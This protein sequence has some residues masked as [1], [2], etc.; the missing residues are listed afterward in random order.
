M[1]P[2]SPTNYL[3]SQIEP[4]ALMAFEGRLT[5]MEV[6]RGQVLQ[7]P[8]AEVE[9]VYFP[10]TA[11]L[12]AGA[13]TSAG[14][15]VNVDLIGAEGACGAFEACG[16][17]Q[18]FARLAVLIPGKTWRMAAPAYRELFDRSSALRTAVHKHAEL[19]I[20]E[21]RQFV[22]CNALHTVENRTCRTLL[23]LFDRCLGERSLPLTRDTLA[24]I[25]G[26]QRTTAVAAV[27]SLQR[28]GHIRTRRGVIEILDVAA[29]RR[30]ACTCRD[31]VA[32]ARREI[33]AA[34]HTA[35]EA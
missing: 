19:L 1:S 35:C 16:S 10:E 25:L 13:E 29:L 31:A 3:L 30:T 5:L 22:A 9:Y 33:Q 28:A 23:D 24:Q 7:E 26:V 15:I 11:V 2:S 17:R 14:E 12:S 21:A 34:D 32:F 27:A 18:A 8:G 4:H 20:A 6:I